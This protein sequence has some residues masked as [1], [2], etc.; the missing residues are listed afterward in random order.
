M[1]HQVSDYILL[2][3]IWEFHHVAFMPSQFCQICSCPSRIRQTYQIKVNKCSCR[4]D[5]SPCTINAL[6]ESVSSAGYISFT[7]VVGVG[8]VVSSLVRLPRGAVPFAASFRSLSEGGG[9]YRF[10]SEAAPIEATNHY[11]LRH[12]FSLSHSSASNDKV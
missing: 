8:H 10:E 6:A 2:T 4:P 7:I 3:L 5:G 11:E 12:R 1:A 9:L